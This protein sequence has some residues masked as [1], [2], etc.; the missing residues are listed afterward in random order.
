MV[1]GHPLMREGQRAIL[2]SKGYI[3]IVGEAGTG[4]EA[5]RLVKETTPDVVIGDSELAVNP[6]GSS[7]V[8]R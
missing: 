2:S 4:L 6:A 8:G 3:R 7:C 1:D 5:L